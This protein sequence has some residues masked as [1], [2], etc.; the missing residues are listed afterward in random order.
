MIGK[1]LR[2]A[3]A[4]WAPDVLILVGAIVALYGVAQIYRPAAIILG[5]LGLLVTGRVLARSTP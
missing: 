4:D 2:G 1:N 5:G 3:L